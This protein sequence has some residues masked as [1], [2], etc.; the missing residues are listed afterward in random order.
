MII[1]TVTSKGSPAITS[2]RW[3]VVHSRFRRRGKGAMPFDR[4]IVSEHDDRTGCRAAARALRAELRAKAS[5][6]LAERDEVFVRRPNFK[7]LKAARRRTKP[8]E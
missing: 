7:S 3:H 2:D 6:P 5:Q 1:E 8:S 4:V